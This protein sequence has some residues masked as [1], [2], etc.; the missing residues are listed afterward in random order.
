MSFVIALAALR[1]PH[2]ALHKR[3]AGH[4]IVL[5]NVLFTPI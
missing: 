4:E 3:N 1:S 2:L 5:E